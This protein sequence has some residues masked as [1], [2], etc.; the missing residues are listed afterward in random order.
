MNNDAFKVALIN[1]DPAHVTGNVDVEVELPSGARYAATFFHPD[2]IAELMDRYQSSG[3][4]AGGLYVWA[5]HMIIIRELSRRAIEAAVADLV[6]SDQ[7]S[8]AFEALT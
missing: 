3:E 8:S 6:A 2:N 7:L 1:F 4:C 5:S